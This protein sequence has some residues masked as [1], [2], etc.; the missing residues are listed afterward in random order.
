MNDHKPNNLPFVNLHGQYKTN[1][2]SISENNNFRTSNTSATYTY[3]RYHLD[4][5]KRTVIFEQRCIF[6]VLPIMLPHDLN[7][8]KWSQMTKQLNLTY[9]AYRD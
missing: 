5:Q 2:P 9:Q 6:I 4:I 8:S 1:Q 7:D 3:A